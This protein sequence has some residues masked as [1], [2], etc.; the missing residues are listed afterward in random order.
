MYDCHSQQAAEALTQE[1]SPC[2]ACYAHTKALDEPDIH[3]DIGGR[4]EGQEYKGRFGIAHSGEYTCSN[5]VKEQEGKS[6]DIN[7]QIQG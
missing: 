1:S 5:I 6:L 4:R 3:Q 2:N 7:I